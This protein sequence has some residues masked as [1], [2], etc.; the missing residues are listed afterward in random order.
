MGNS[1]F[2]FKQFTLF[3]DKCAMKVGTDG[4]L[5]GAWSDVMNAAKILDV[6][7]GCG[8]IALMLA[9]RNPKPTITA[10]DIDEMAANQ[11]EQNIID[12]PF[13]DR[14]EVENISLQQ[15]AKKKP[16]AFDMVVSNPPFF[17]NS[18]LSPDARRSGARHSVNLTLEDL[19]IYSKKCLAP[20]GVMSLILPYNNVDAI[21][22]LCEEY[23]YY[24]KRKV[25]VYPTI[26]A[27]PK[28]L[29]VELSLN[30]VG[31]TILD[32][33]IIEKERHH[34]SNEFSELVK[35]FYL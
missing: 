11:A 5:L 33:L 6:G 19:F 15:F 32:T 16:A 24:V 2:R 25:I 9:Q 35:D 17:A 27:K 30:P 21:D 31:K 26:D 13:S 23:G 14:I 4:V 22:V 28:R 10:I 3:H 34:Y 12:S 18:L 1:F 29:L 7:T 20:G 8:L